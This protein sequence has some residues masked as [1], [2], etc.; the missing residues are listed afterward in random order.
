MYTVSC[1]PNTKRCPYKAKATL[2]SCFYCYLYLNHL[3]DSTNLSRN[4]SLMKVYFVL[5]VWMLKCKCLTANVGPCSTRETLFS[6][7]CWS[8]ENSHWIYSWGASFIRFRPWPQF[9]L[10][11]TSYPNKIMLL[12]FFWL[13]F[14]NSSILILVTVRGDFHRSCQRSQGGNWGKINVISLIYNHFCVLVNQEI[15]RITSLSRRNI[16]F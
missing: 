13:F 4:N 11:T 12:F 15:I 14:T 2:S 6:C 3:E 16:L 5:T 1:D 9:F 10:V 7:M 8:L